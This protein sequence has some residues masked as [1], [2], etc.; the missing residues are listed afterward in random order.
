MSRSHS[1]VVR[2]VW[3]LRRSACGFTCRCHVTVLG[4]TSKAATHA[5]SLEHCDADGFHPKLPMAPLYSSTPLLPDENSVPVEVKLSLD[6][7][8]STLS[9]IEEVLDSLKPEPSQKARKSRRRALQRAC[10]QFSVSLV[11]FC[12]FAGVAIA[13]VIL[14]INAVGACVPILPSSSPPCRLAHSKYS[15][16]NHV[17]SPFFMA[18]S[19]TTTETMPHIVSSE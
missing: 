19:C 12:I 11:P 17:C 18:V 16:Y 1:E 9:L 5:D 8:L 14:W 2:T 13:T 7:A 3:W 10:A 15:I 4:H 6:V